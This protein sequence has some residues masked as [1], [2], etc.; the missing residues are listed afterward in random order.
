[1]GHHKLNDIVENSLRFVEHRLKEQ[2]IRLGKA[3]L[4]DLPEI[5]GDA[6]NISQVIINIIVNALDSMQTG[7]TLI[8]KTGY[9]DHLPSSV[10]VVITDNG[11]GIREEILNKIF[12]PFF[13]TKE[14]GSGL[15][16]AISKRIMEDHN[17]NI[18][19][20]STVGEGTTFFLCLPVRK[21]TAPA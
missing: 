16:L 18:T 1:M 6:N 12:N 14:M 13:T 2:E 7:G 9:C 10:Q 3:L 19:V 4:P 17:G 5:Y 21:A 20:K 11:S 8:V 15:G